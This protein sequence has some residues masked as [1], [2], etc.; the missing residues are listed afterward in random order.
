MLNAFKTFDMI[1]TRG[2]FVN[3]DCNS[4]AAQNKQ[5]VDIRSFDKKRRLALRASNSP[6][7][8]DYKRNMI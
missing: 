3:L 8:K 1:V 4:V 2:V 7:K 6:C 5:Y